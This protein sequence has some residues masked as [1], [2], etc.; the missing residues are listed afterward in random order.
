[1][2]P[3]ELRR[4]TLPAYGS[5]TGSLVVGTPT[6]TSVSAP[7][8]FARFLAACS[9]VPSMPC[10]PDLWP[11]LRETSAPVRRA[12]SLVQERWPRPISGRP[13]DIRTCSSVFSPRGQ[14]CGSMN[15]LPAG[16]DQPDAHLGGRSPPQRHSEPRPAASPL[17]Q[18]PPYVFA[19][20]GAS[21]HAAGTD[22][23]SASTPTVV[24]CFATPEVHVMTLDQTSGVTRAGETRSCAAR[25]SSCAGVTRAR[26]RGGRRRR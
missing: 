21:L 18:P 24:D 14:A 17:R 5:H 20:R 22:A 8:P 15:H 6:R 4:R 19:C 13:S 10:S 23:R 26:A 1:M 3:Q 2:V 25:A 9:C 7:A 16:V 11:S 12:F